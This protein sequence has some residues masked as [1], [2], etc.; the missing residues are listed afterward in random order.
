MK[1]ILFIILLYFSS[2]ALIASDSEDLRVQLVIRDLLSETHKSI[3]DKAHKKFKISIFKINNDQYF[4]VSNFSWKRA[5]LGNSHYRI[6]YNPKIFDNQISDE[7]LK[8]VLAHELIHTED[9]VQGNTFNS[10]IPIGV[11]VSF[12]ESRVQYERKTD[13]KVIVKG[14]GRELFEYRNW[15]YPLLSEKELL[16]KKK[17]YLTPEEIS[18]AM[19]IQESNP[20]LIQ[21]WLKNKVPLNYEQMKKEFDAT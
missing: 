19:A 7:A 6:G 16:V 13:L 10:I 18:F 3:K 20:K 17:E 15:Q 9:Y 12:K 21:Y 11:K 8:G 4:F 14:L 5:V 1:K 2:R